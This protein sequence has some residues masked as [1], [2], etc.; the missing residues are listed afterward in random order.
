MKIEKVTRNGL[1]II[2]FSET[3]KEVKK[4]FKIQDVF[5]TTL[6]VRNEIE[7]YSLMN[8]TIDLV[9]WNQSNIVV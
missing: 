3:F 2:S 7:N 6:I 4:S 9:S 5:E 1:I 8:Y